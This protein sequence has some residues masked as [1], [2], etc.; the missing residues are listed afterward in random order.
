MQALVKYHGLKDWNLR[1][2]Y[3]DSISVNTTCMKTEA[4]LTDERR[5]GVYVDGR[6]NDNANGRLSV[7]VSRLSPGARVEDFRIDSGNSPPGR[8]K[9]I[10][11]SS[12][13][14]AALTVLA[15][16]K[17]VGGTPDMKD[18]SRVA[19]LFAASAS[20]SLVGGFSRLYAG[21]D[22]E[23]TYAERF[24]DERDM[25]LRMVIVPMRS[26]VRTEDAHSEVLTSP[27]FKARVESAQKRCDE[28]EK[29]IRGND[30]KAVG[31][32]AERDTLELHSLT[33]TGENRMIIMTE[34]T[35]RIIQ[36]VRQL[37]AD[38]E[39]AYFSM[40]TGPSVFI[41]TSERSQGR[42]LAAVKRLGFKAYASG[43]GGEA[44]L[45]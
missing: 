16:A 39:D 19:R 31:V 43:V 45:V 18:L 11:Y 2:P 13:A 9:G 41:N 32:L 33:M 21:D 30:L 7:V 28:M 10:G 40:Q 17:L 14:G 5:G 26:R 37:K 25:D 12:S 3:H 27:F 36:K 22:D 42:V 20:R 35:L 29:A 23:G 8:P 34:E 1:L 38:G 15:H 24:A 4:R 6:I 44:R